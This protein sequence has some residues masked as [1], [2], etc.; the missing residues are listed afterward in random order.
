MQLYLKENESRCRIA[1]TATASLYFASK[2]DF[3]ASTSIQIR[4]TFFDDSSDALDGLSSTRYR[5]I[6]L[7]N[8]Q[9]HFNGT[10]VYFELVS[11]TLHKSELPLDKTLDSPIHRTMSIPHTM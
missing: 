1:S 6:Y 9:W 7:E 11:S 10:Q 3:G 2:S 8:D 4:V 5:V